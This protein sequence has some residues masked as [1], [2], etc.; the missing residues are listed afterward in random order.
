M[1][2]VLII[3]AVLLCCSVA[4]A[5]YTYFTAAL[6]HE[7]TNPSAAPSQA[8]SR[9]RIDQ[10]TRRLWVWN[11]TTLQWVKLGQG[12]DIVIGGVAPSYAPVVGQSDFAMNGNKELYHYS[13]VGVVWDC[14]NCASSGATNLTFTG[15]A[16]PYSLNS[17]TGADVT[18]SAGANITLTRVSNNLEIAAAGGGTVSTDA[19]LSGDGSG[20]SPLKIAQQS[21]TASKVLE[22][23]GAT[24]EP[25][26]GN[27]Y[28]FVTS[29]ATIT[30]AVNEILIGTLSA[31]VTMGL[32]TCNATTD[33]KWFKFVRNGS[34]A[35][36]VTIDPAGSQQF[37]DGTNTKISYGKL[38]IDCTCRFS[39]G[40][41][42]WFFDNF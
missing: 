25:T 32:P 28:T 16:S 39:G 41:G 15:G 12:I 3:L 6:P 21:A 26:W 22:W 35:F 42:V 13:G 30:T 1:R 14:L 31:N 34:D 8:G 9:I 4:T 27:P 18:F 40:T 38:S 7:I 20:G 36:S 11:E 33:M 17:S 10:P 5:Q 37:Y 19:T 29:G 24:W 2:V 23:T